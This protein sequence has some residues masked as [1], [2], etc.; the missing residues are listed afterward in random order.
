MMRNNW[1][2]PSALC[3]L[4]LLTACGSDDGGDDGGGDS[5]AGQTYLLQIAPGDFGPGIGQ[6]LGDDA[7][8]E[9]ALTIGGAPDAYAVTLNTG[10]TPMDGSPWQQELCNPTSHLTAG[11]SAYPGFAL[12][13][14][15]L[16]IYLRHPNPNMQASA[17]ATAH[18]FTLTNVLL[19]DGVTEDE[20]S[21]TLSAILDAREIY[22]VITALGPGA[23]EDDLCSYVAN[24]NIDTC[25]PCPGTPDTAVYCLN[26][27]AGYLGAPAAPITPQETAGYADT[28]FFP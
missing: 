7:V 4:P 8:P 20:G 13:P 16:P 27:T 28:C 25:K 14:V 19:P 9:F 24:N 26:L 3:L 22:P 2:V 18:Q 1:V 15:E 21:G 10:Q 17:R 12:G 23:N 6:E 11:A 5:F